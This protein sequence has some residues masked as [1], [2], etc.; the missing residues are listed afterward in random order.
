MASRTLA[1]LPLCDLSQRQLHGGSLGEFDSGSNGMA[2]TQEE[3]LDFTSDGVK[4]EE[5][6]WT[7][8]NATVETTE[9][10]KRLVIESQDDTTPYPHTE[11]F[12]LE[13]ENED[14]QRIGRG[15]ARKFALA[16]TGSPQVVPSKLIGM[17][18]LAT[19]GEDKKGF[20]RLSQYKPLPKE[21]EASL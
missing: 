11:R 4:T 10:G 14:A 16:V 9:K 15:Q 3:V 7:I 21:V 12:W 13:H 5:K 17:K 2:G 19:I 1:L 18:Y 8:I 6:A 20:V